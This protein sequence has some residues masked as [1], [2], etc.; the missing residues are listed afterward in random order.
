MRSIERWTYFA[1]ITA[2]VG[3]AIAFFLP[4]YRSAAGNIEHVDEWFLFF[5][6]VPAIVFL[7]FVSNRWL[8]AILCGL[9]IIAGAISLGMLTFLA[10]FKSM[11]LMGFY[12]ARASLVILMTGWL[13]LSVITLRRTSPKV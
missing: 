10:S 2:V 4:F 7:H 1:Q 11:P 3:L 8:K 6:T 13:V 12:L 9:A 5:W